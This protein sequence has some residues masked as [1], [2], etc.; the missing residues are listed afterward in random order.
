[1]KEK[2][3]RSLLGL[4]GIVMVIGM[5]CA[6]NDD[7]EDIEL[8]EL[9]LG[10]PQGWEVAVT[11]PDY[12]EPCG[13]RAL[14]EMYFEF[15]SETYEVYTKASPET[16][17]TVHSKQSLAFYRPLTDEQVETCRTQ[18]GKKPGTAAVQLEPSAFSEGRYWVTEEYWIVPSTLQEHPR[19]QELYEYL[20]EFFAKR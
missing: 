20:K 14:F 1:M 10:L 18:E 17:E 15:P 12:N 5:A 2:A 3:T 7:T 16:P 8:D 19:E 13:H 4:I 6:R 11:H 9:I